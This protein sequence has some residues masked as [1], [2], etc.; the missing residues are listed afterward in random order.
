MR[1]DQ[2]PEAI[3]QELNLP[4]P[5]QNGHALSGTEQKARKAQADRLVEYALDSKAKRFVDQ[6]GAPHVLLDGEAVPLTYSAYGWLRRLIY[7]K[8]GIAPGGEALKTSVGMLSALT[9]A[10]G[11]ERELHTRS[12]WHEGKVYYQLGIR[13]VIEIS[14]DGWRKVDD[15]PV[16]FRKVRNLKS[17]PDPE[18][19]GSLEDLLALT[20]LKSQKDR[21]LLTS[22][23][24]TIP[25]P[26]VPRPILGTTGVMGSGKTTLNRL[27]KRSLDPS[28]PETVRIDPRDFLQKC[29]HAYVAM[30]DNQNSLPEWAV[31][32]LCRLVTGE[33][34][35]KRQLYT[36][37][38]D[39]IY[40]MKRAVLL[41]GINPPTDRGDAQDRTLPIELDRVKNHERRS[42]EEMWAA[43]EEKHPK[44]L[45][46]IFDVLAGALR[47]KPRLQL[48]E[49]P[50]L[51]DWGEYA[52]AVYEHLEFEEDRKKGAALFLVDWSGVVAVQNQTAL[53]GSPV[54]QTIVHFMQERDHWE[55]YSSDLHK[56]L[57]EA[58]ED[59]KINVARDRTWPKSP[60]WLW[61]RIKEVL[62]LLAALGITA[63][64]ESRAGGSW[65]V[66]EK[67]GPSG[68]GGSPPPDPGSIAEDYGSISADA[69]SDASISNPDRYAGSESSGG[70]GS[71]GGSYPGISPR[72]GE[73]KSS[74]FEEDQGV[75]ANAS[76]ALNAS[77]PRGRRLSA[78]EAEEVKRLM[79]E[80]M[81]P[82]LARAEVLGEDVEP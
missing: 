66:L 31:D 51:A 40:E 82:A 8:E 29:A 52:A 39:I 58:A 46:A 36:D 50:R 53:D 17:L 11:M 16:V 60:S 54:A 19:G 21:R 63:A 71:I 14:G 1:H 35:S 5:E 49:R 27:I 80:G 48:R 73:E 76:S 57:E 43:F 26:H 65:I 68:E 69:S 25:L 15:P 24:I 20:N 64:K 75:P 62:P 10:E 78:E 9:E 55:S 56:K 72:T 28:V 13:R 38:E 30:L 4:K 67:E 7:D 77:T 34:D 22:Y 44:I 18:E 59:L 45:G 33:G 37:D 81:D 61:R 41:N 23:V 6:S 47:Q 3:L 42:E 79:R 74:R 70:T 32:T 12:A 2:P